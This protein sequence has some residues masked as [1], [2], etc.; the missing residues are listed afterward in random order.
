MNAL[1]QGLTRALCARIAAATFDA[2]GDECVRRV[3]QAIR[4]GIAVAVAGVDERAPQAL[5]RHVRA[6]GGEPQAT[7]WRHGFRT[8]TVQAAYVNGVAVHAL[9]FEPMWLPPT[10]AVSPVL[11]VAM[12]LAESNGLGGREVIA[13]VARGMELQGR[14]Q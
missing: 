5:A 6:L 7:V 9:D 14:M 3:K 12:A 1:P 10:H 8:S 2:L 11:P 13:A 4:D